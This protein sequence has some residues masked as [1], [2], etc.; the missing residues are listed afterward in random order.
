MWP[1]AGPDRIGIVQ[2]NFK[3]VDLVL[4]SVLFSGLH[5]LVLCQRLEVELKW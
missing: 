3:T 1:L 4:F 2:I 5:M